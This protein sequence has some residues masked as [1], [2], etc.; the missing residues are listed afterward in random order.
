MLSSWVARV[1]GADHSPPTFIGRSRGGGLL[2]APGP[3]AALGEDL[4]GDALG[5]HAVVLQL[6]QLLRGL[7]HV[8]HWGPSRVGLESTGHHNRRDLLARWACQLARPT[9]ISRLVCLRLRRVSESGSACHSLSLSGLK[10]MMV[11]TAGRRSDNTDDL[12]SAWHHHGHML[13]MLLGLPEATLVIERCVH[14]AP[15]AGLVV[16]RSHLG[17]L[18]QCL[19]MDCGVDPR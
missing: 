11:A 15:A 7:V 4:L 3:A 19:V 16:L 5:D 10:S 2:A 6:L 1:L 12:A 9:A 17:L 13:L 8:R 14:L 18:F